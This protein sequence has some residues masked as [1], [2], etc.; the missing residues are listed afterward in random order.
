VFRESAC[1]RHAAPS[2]WAPGR[3]IFKFTGQI[4][5]GIDIPSAC[6]FSKLP[7]AASV[8]LAI[9]GRLELPPAAI[10]IKGLPDDFDAW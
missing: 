7:P 10:I 9:V 2:L 3:P 6:S 5:G 8:V 1:H 4:H